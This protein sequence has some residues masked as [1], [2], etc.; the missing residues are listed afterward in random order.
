MELETYKETRTYV[1]L[2]NKKLLHYSELEKEVT[3]LK[4]ENKRLK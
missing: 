1:D 2:Q 4:E 3:E